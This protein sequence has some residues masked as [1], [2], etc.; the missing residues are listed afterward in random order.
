ITMNP[1]WKIISAFYETLNTTNPNA[2]ISC[3]LCYST[4]PPYYEAIGLETTYSFSAEEIPPQC[5]WGD[6]KR[7]LTMQHVIGAGT[8][9]G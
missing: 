1:L 9:I 2:T 4:T 8:C 7:G 3:W 5:K 6:R